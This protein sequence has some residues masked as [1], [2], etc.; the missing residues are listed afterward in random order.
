M[1][2]GPAVFSIKTGAPIVPCF[3]LYQ[4]DRTYSLEFE[5]PIDPPVVMDGTIEE[6]ILMSM[7]N[8]Y[9]TVIEQKIRQYPTQWLMFREF[10]K[11]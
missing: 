2:K 9:V 6:S 1:P 7:M 5:Q 3:M 10:W 11:Q 4:N 8:Q